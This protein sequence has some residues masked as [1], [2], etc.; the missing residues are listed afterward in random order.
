[1]ADD[2]QVETH[3]GICKALKEL[4]STLKSLEQVVGVGM[5][6]WGLD[7]PKVDELIGKGMMEKTYRVN[8]VL[9]DMVQTWTTGVLVPKAG[10]LHEEA[11]WELDRE[12]NLAIASD[13]QAEGALY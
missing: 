3:E 13:E 10:A 6:G 11:V 7:V 5:A 8:D 9:A 4:A 2:R 12:C 1:M